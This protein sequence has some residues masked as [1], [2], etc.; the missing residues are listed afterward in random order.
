MKAVGCKRLDRDK[1]DLRPLC[2]SHLKHLLGD[3]FRFLL[4]QQYDYGI[5]S[6]DT[7]YSA[8]VANLDA[9]TLSYVSDI[10]LSPPNSDKYHT[11]SQRLI[12]QFSDSETQKIKKL[13]TDLQLG[14]EK[15]S[16]LFRKMKEL[17]N[18]QLQDDFLQSLW[19][20]R[21]PP[22]IQTVLSASSEPLDKLAIIADK[23]SEVVGSSSTICAATTVPPPSQS[24]SCSVQPTMDS[25]ARQIQELSLQVAELTRERNSSRH[26]RYSSDRRRSHS[27]SRSVN[28]GSGICYYHRRYKEQARKCVSPCAFVQK[29][30]S[31]VIAGMAEPSKHTSRLFLLDRK[32]GQKF[33]I[34][35][36]SEICV[37]PPSPTMNK[38]PQSNFSL[39]AANNTKIPA[40]GMVCKE[41]NLGLRRPFIW[42]FII[43]DVS[44]PIIGADFLKHFNLLIDL[45]K[46]RLVDVETSLFTS[47]VF[48]NI[49]QPSILTLDANISFK[50]ILSEYPDLSNPL[51]S[52]SASHGTVHHIITT[53]PPVT[54]RPRRLHPK[55]YDAVK[56][57][58]EFLLAQGIIKPSKSPWSSPLHVVPKSDSTV[59][60]VGDYRQLNSVT[61]FDSYPMPYLNDFAHALHG[62]KIFSKIDI[63]KAFHQIPIAE[64]DIPKTAVT[65]PWRLYE[66]THLCFGLVNAPQTF[67][68]F[69]HEVLRGLPFCFVYLDDIL[70]YSEN[71][72]EHR[73][74]LRNIFQRLSSYGL[75]LNISKCVF[76][77][78]ELIFL[79][80]L[81]T[82]DGIKPLP[83]KVQAV[84]DYKQPETVGSLRKFLGLLNFYRRF[85][86]KAAE[87]QYLLS[88]FLKGSKGK[89]SKP[90]NWS[91]EAI[92]AFQRCKQALAD[93]ALLAHLSPSAP[94]ALHVD[95]SDY[96]IGGAL[97][98][99]VD[100]ELRPLAFFSR[101]LTSSEKSY[102]AYDRE[103]LAIYS[104]IRHFRYM[105]E[106]R[107]FTVFTD[108]KPLTYAFRQKRSDNIAA[109]VLSRVSAIT[110][111]SQID[112][113]CIAETQQTDQEL[114]TLIA[115]GTSL[116]LKKVTFPNSSTEIMCDLSTGTA[117]PYIPKQHRQD[118]FSAM[119]NLSHPGIRRSVHLMKQR[120]VWPSISSD[121]AKWAR[122]CLAC[123]KSKIHRHTRSPLSSFQEPSQRFDHVHLDLIGP[124]PPSNGYTYCL[125]MIDRFSKW[126]EAQPLKDITAETVAFFSSWVSR[127]GTPAILTTDRGRQFESSLFKALSKLLG[128]QKCRTTGYHPQVNGMIE[129]L[130]R[131]LKSAIKCHATERWTE[132]LPIILLGLRASLNEDILCTP[133]ELVFGT[134]I[135]LP[136]EMFDSSKPDDDVNFV[137]KLKSHT[138]SLHPKPPKHHG[139]RPV[140]IHPGLLEATH[141]FLRRDMLPRPLQQPYDGPFKV[142]QR[143]DKVFFLDINGK[144]VSVS[145]DRCKPAFFL[146][147]EDLQLPQTKNETPATVEPN[148]T[149]STPATVESDPTAST[150]TQPS[151]RSGRKVHLPT[152]YR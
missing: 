149:A 63:F 125:T 130:H 56:V 132:V 21:M 40:Y 79:G 140:F 80:H 14:D 13:L 81:I 113:D 117:R 110:F 109:D 105:L 66:Y 91:S 47:C 127:F 128:V 7:K 108:H 64:C 95:A 89:D 28:R 111:P 50:N 48:S 114:H 145:I 118:V 147:T 52:K 90:L 45:K 35:S 121:V 142:L 84:L 53:G 24:S 16:H 122:H 138:Q 10:V 103:L 36:G 97:H 134:T 5:S 93:A 23:V 135:R 51:I 61:E 78:T 75:K 15:P 43:A 87:Q 123:Q 148:A 58:F 126:P 86:P 54:A 65:T 137:S 41:L 116:E 44:S 107:D 71:A 82:P 115:S 19:L 101:K 129:E 139:K 60:P 27:R 39:F 3:S 33:L 92:A 8:L 29:R 22:H 72:E 34:D 30:V 18:G 69:M 104:A 25:L 67:M 57:E 94:L 98:Q 76:G 26:Q 59:R 99:V 77:V 146:N 74:H 55:L 124:L 88:E 136:G 20:Q 11:L 6:D 152:R 32:S 112:Y 1:D 102:S 106:A 42:T 143:K 150:P 144:R 31:Y 151:T 17:S 9:E 96:A 133:A 85:L 38:S 73:S 120:F 70:C 46:K 100:S 37:I 62:K 119:H 2:Q 68:R 12:T 4:I 49:V 83:E 131:P 141:V